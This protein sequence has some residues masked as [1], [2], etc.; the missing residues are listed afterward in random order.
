MDLRSGELYWPHVAP[1]RLVDRYAP[2]DRDLRCDIAVIGGGVTGA[3][4]AYH[5]A[6]AGAAVV[7]LDRRP[8]GCGSTAASTG[9]LQY[10]ID[11]PLYKL[12]EL[13][14]PERAQRAYRLCVRCL[15]DMRALAS[16]LDDDCALIDRPS[17]YLGC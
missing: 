16:R 10:E 1:A 11:T 4:A 13:I 7:V 6:Q 8:I 2:L 5:L 15:S 14:G 9:L 3:F 12:T 17:L